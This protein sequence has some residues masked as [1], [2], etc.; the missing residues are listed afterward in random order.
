MCM[1]ER[2]A[3]MGSRKERTRGKERVRMYAFVCV[4]E[5]VYAYVHERERCCDG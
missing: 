2:D 4:R 1:S 5:C 3:A